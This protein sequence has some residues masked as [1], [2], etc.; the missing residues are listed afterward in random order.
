MQPVDARFVKVPIQSRAQPGYSNFTRFQTPKL[1]RGVNLPAPLGEQDAR[2]T[3]Y[4]S[5]CR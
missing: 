1:Q 2:L 5:A 4:H 3:T